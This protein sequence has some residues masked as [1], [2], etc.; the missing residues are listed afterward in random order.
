MQHYEK[1]HTETRNGFEIVFSVAPEDIHP[2][3]LFDDSVDDI[4]E[5]C[6]KI[7]DGSYSWFVARVQ[8]FRCGVELAD[9]YLGGNLYDNVK[10]FITESGGYYEDMVQNVITYANHKLEELATA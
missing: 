2:A 8:A 1:I 3:D 7:D 6:R 10:D 4:Q 5:I 9:D